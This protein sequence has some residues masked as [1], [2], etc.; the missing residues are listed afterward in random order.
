VAVKFSVT[1]IHI[2]EKNGKGFE[3][4]WSGAVDSIRLLQ[5]RN[6]APLKTNKLPG[7]IKGRKSLYKQN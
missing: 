6:R 2:I 7:S 4:L 5:N 1:F 3:V